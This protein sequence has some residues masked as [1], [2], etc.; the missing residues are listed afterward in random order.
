[1]D[2]DTDKKGTQ[3]SGETLLLCFLEVNIKVYIQISICIFPEFN[4]KRNHIQGQ[5]KTHK[6]VHCNTVYMKKYGSDF[7]T[8]A[9]GRL[10]INYSTFT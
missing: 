5:R 7:P 10:N 2:F 8:A 1:M 6:N 9:V 4:L 3:T